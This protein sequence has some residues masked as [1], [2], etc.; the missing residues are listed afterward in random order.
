MLIAMH[1]REGGGGGER[2]LKLIGKI[3]FYCLTR[4]DCHPYSGDNKSS[5]RARI[6]FI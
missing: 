4:F 6:R 2:L 3:P 5:Q 1:R